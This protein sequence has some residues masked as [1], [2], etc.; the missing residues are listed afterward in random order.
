MFIY[1]LPLCKGMLNSYLYY[2]T[3]FT[4]EAET[5][6]KVY[7]SLYGLL[8]YCAGIRDIFMYSLF[9]ICDGSFYTGHIYITETSTIQNNSFYVCSIVPKETELGYTRVLWVELRDCVHQTLFQCV[10]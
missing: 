10:V 4:N 6:R 3:F 7:I 9:V 5:N 2:A 8:L 1:L